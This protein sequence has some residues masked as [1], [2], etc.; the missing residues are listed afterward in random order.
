MQGETRTRRVP[1][2]PAS[3]SKGKQSGIQSRSGILELAFSV[4]KGRAWNWLV[5]EVP[6]TSDYL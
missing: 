6:P 3:T 2:G 5:F 4:Y 1:C